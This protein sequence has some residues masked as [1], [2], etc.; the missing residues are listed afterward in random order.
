M[1]EDLQY[2]IRNNASTEEQSSL[3][4]ETGA[5]LMKQFPS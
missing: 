2:L 1:R 3:I 5:K 4:S